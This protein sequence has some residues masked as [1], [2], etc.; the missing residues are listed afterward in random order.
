MKT[1]LCNKLLNKSLTALCAAVTMLVLSTSSILA[2]EISDE[3]Y[4]LLQEYKKK[5]A[6]K[7]LPAHERPSKVKQTISRPRL[8]K[9]KKL[10]NSCRRMKGPLKQSH[11]PVGTPTSPQRPPIRFQIWF[12]LRFRMH[13]V[14]VTTIRTATL[15]CLPSRRW[16]PSSCPGIKCRC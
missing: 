6:E 13:I 11:Q 4:K 8:T 12:R 1:K 14:R 2:V 16:C 5:L 15:M 9:R 3:D 10:K 7:Q